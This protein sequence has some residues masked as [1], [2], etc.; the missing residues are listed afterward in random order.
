M[1]IIARR[2]IIAA[3]AMVVGLSVATL[4]R[5]QASDNAMGPQPCSWSSGVIPDTPPSPQ[6]IIVAPSVA[7]AA[8][9]SRVDPD[10]P[11]DA[12]IQGTVVLCAVIAKDGGIDR[13]EYVSGPALLIGS[14][15]DAARQWRYK[16]TLL[17][18][19]PVEVETRIF[20]D[21][22]S[23]KPA[24]KKRSGSEKSAAVPAR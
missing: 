19:K 10:Y 9:I 1:G 22:V 18:G 4:A 2:T 5:A 7:T 23:K 14:A 17:D 21:F 20:V 16:R 8:L 6:R 3:S 11:P 24:L 15:M 13:L 12:R